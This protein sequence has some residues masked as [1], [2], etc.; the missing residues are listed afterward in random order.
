[1]RCPGLST[2]VI[3]KLVW[4][5][6][7]HR[8]VRSALAV[9]AIGVEVTMIL[10][11]VGL[12]RGTVEDMAQR[13]RGVGA[14]ILVRAPGTSLIGLS[15]ATMNQK[16]LGFLE[17]QPHVRA[18]AGTVV[19][20][21]GGVSSVTGLD[22]EEFNRVSGGFRYLAGRPFRHDDE[23]IVDAYYARQNNLR[24]G[25]T[26]RLLNRDWRV[27]GIVEPGKLAR[28]VIARD[29]LQNLVGATGKLSSIFV[30]LDDP[31]NTDRVIASLKQQLPDYPI[32]SMEELTSLYSVQNV[33]GLKAFTGVVVSLAVVVGFLVV[34][35]SMY[36]AVLERTREIGILKALGASPGYILNVVFRETALMALAGSAVGILMTFGTRWAV[37]TLIPASL[38]QKIVPEW[39][40]IAAAIAVG[41]ALAGALYPAWKAAGQDAIQA[42]A[43][44]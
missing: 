34:F 12:S 28:I 4:E 41:G 43:Y 42:L 32:Y 40:P 29:T 26:V 5:N 15:S 36:T 10:T 39:W 18:V 27:C 8:P 44:E 19:H 24:V 33:P 17:Q 9:L 21:I 20:P 35:L 38:V 31:A 6:L 1:M 16:L 11:L 30:K 37:M 14:D 3:N 23:V 22:L 25:A 7:K 2:P 13:A